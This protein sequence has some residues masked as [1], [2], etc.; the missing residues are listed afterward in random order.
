MMHN[1]V[2]RA[3]QRFHNCYTQ[4][5]LLPS[6]ILLKPGPQRQVFVAGVEVNAT[7][8]GTGKGT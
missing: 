5:P 1:R 4:K 8:D 2:G 6:G 7:L 3:L